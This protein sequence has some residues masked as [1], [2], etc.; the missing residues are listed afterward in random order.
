MPSQ[1]KPDAKGKD[2]KP[3]LQ[4]TS[5]Q[6]IVTVCTLVVV[7]GGLLV[8]GLIIGRYEERSS[9]SNGQTPAESKITT[10]PEP[11]GSPSE[12]VQ[13]TP[14]IPDFQA[15]GPPS[16]T[17]PSPRHVS[18]PAPPGPGTTPITLASDEEPPSLH[19]AEPVIENPIEP[20]PAPDTT[21]PTTDDPTLT[22]SSEEDHA[23]PPSPV[24]PSSPN[25]PAES[26]TPA[27]KPDP[28]TR[29]WAVQ[30]AAFDAATKS[31]EAKRFA[32]QHAELNPE[33]VSSKDG[34]FLRV[35]VGHYG[36]RLSAVARCEELKKQPQF[37]GCFPQTR[38]N[39]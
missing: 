7:A 25:P 39:I 34:R 8:C 6:L 38:D 35:L 30:I 19:P 17:E 33:V 14:K 5:S 23:P 10:Q 4:L 21:P 27:V 24:E 9:Q 18:V 3:A 20:L 1:K 29:P 22:P 37:S 2:G 31:A 32:E 12:G 28:K 26:P 36:D 16:S 13:K 11:A 15:S